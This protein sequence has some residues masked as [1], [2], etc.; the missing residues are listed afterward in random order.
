[1]PREVSLRLPPD[2][3]LDLTSD[4]PLDLTIKS[5]RKRPWLAT[6]KESEATPGTSAQSDQPLDPL[7][8]D[9]QEEQP[10]EAMGVSH[11]AAQG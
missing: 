3:P 9:Q 7:H 10:L 2:K 5:S 8:Q 6:A 4:Q 11:Q 1:M